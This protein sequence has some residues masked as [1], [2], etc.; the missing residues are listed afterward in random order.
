M[1]HRSSVGEIADHAGIPIRT[2]QGKFRNAIG[3]SLQDEMTR[4]RIERVRATCDAEIIR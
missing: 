3:H 2:L 1:K 4:T